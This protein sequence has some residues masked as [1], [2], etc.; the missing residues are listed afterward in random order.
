MLALVVWHFVESSTGR[1]VLLNSPSEAVAYSLWWKHFIRR[2]LFRFPR[3]SLVV[4]DLFY[5]DLPLPFFF[6]PEIVHIFSNFSNIYSSFLQLAKGSLENLGMFYVLH[7]AVSHHCQKCAAPAALQ[8]RSDPLRMRHWDPPRRLTS[9]CLSDN[10][11][12]KS[13][14]P[15]THTHIDSF[16]CAVEDL[17]SRGTY[18][19]TEAR[20]PCDRIRG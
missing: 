17:S 1:G 6:Q 16:D 20:M 18:L 7:T 2:T 15:C 5:I 8:I 13:G 4:L 14:F 3:L 10:T 9:N 11:A 19:F 12:I